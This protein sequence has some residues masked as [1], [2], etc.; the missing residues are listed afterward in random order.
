[1]YFFSFLKQI[2]RLLIF[3]HKKP[4]LLFAWLRVLFIAPFAYKK[5]VPWVS[6]KEIFII[7]Q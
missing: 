6:I 5:E 2:G 4:L 3:V 1:M 7:N